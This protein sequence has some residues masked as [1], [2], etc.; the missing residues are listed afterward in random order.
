MAAWEQTE[1][2]MVDQGLIDRPVGVTRVLM[3]LP[4][5]D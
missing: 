5:S 4:A 2:I 1:S 3:P